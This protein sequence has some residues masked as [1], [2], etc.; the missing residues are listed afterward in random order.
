MKLYAIMRVVIGLGAVAGASL[1]YWD[2]SRKYLDF[3]DRYCGEA[4]A[5]GNCRSLQALAVDG[6][7][8]FFI[9]AMIAL[10]VLILL[11]PP[12]YRGK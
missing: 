4:E 5:G 10:A 7:T 11:P 6:A 2:I 12:K 9:V 3:A 8:P 1:L